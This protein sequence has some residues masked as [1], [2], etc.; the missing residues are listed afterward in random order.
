MTSHEASYYD[1][2][3]F[4]EPEELITLEE[5]REENYKKWSDKMKATETYLEEEIKQYEDVIRVE[6]VDV[7][8][9]IPVKMLLFHKWYGK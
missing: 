9:N 1:I 6:T 4:P 3:F 7:Y 8:E 2:L 5:Q